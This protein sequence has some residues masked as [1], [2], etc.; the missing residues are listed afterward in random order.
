MLIILLITLF[1]TLNS[2]LFINHKYL[3]LFIILGGA[4]QFMVP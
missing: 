1:H 3:F 4:L 2:Y